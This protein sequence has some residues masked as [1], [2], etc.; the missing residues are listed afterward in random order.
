MDVKMLLVMLSWDSHAE[1]APPEN[2]ALF[3]VKLHPTT[4]AVLPSKARAAPESPEFATMVVFTSCTTDDQMPART[5]T[6]RKS[7]KS[8]NALNCTNSK[9]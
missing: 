3:C 5:K 9:L 8:D 7:L 4:T 6:Q 1:T 2:A